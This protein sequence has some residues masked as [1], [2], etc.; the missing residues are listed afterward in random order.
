MSVSLPI[1]LPE[2]WTAE[3]IR[4]YGVVIEAYSPDGCGLGA[5]TVSEEARG[6]ALGMAPV[7]QMSVKYTGR[8]WRERLYADAVAQL[9]RSITK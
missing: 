2:H 6:Y 8:G 3:A 5:I 1:L 7:W 4:S 9:Q